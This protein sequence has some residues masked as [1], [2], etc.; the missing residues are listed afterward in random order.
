MVHMGPVSVPENPC[1]LVG[2]GGRVTEAVSTLGAEAVSTLGEQG[3]SIVT[4]STAD[5]LPKQSH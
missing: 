1:R 4:P 5:P 3:G 2:V